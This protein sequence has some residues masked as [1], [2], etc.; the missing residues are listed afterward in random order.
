MIPEY[1][2]KIKDW[3]VP[4][5]G[6]KVASFLGFIGYYRTFVPHYSALM[7]RLNGIKK[8]EKFLWKEKI[9]R[10]FMELKKAFTKG[11][12]QAFLDFGVEDQF[13]LTTDSSKENIAGML[14]EYRTGRRDS[15]GRKCN[16]Y[17]QNYPSY[18]GE[19]LAVIQCI[20]IWRRI[21]SYPPFE[22]HTDASALKYQSGLFARWY[23]E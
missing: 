22:V 7:N 1:V 19:L 3:P 13:I 14:S 2:Q 4:K 20:W 10:D 6:K 21:L 18:K 17:E 8:V 11:G 5:T 16:K 9:K 15:L 12:I 23:Q